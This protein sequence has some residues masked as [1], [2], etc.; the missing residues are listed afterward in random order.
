M[1]MRVASILR[2]RSP[3]WL[4]V[5]LLV[6]AIEP[7]SAARS[8]TDLF[9]E[10]G[11]PLGYALVFLFA[12]IPWFEIF[13]VIPV[14][15]GL[16]MNAVAVA[17]FAF[18]GNALSVYAVIAF[19]GRVRAWWTRRRTE[20]E[21][22]E[23]AGGRARAIWDRYGLAG[24]ALCSPMVTGVHLAALIALATGSEKRAVGAWLTASIALWTVILTAVSYYGFDFVA[25]L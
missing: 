13:L 6:I 5:G 4:V 17:V 3:P 8:A 21:P 16:G 7:V 25:G 2:R 22:R 24:L 12:A 19:H 15:I 1:T 11:G 23:R 18:L 14:G 20:G 9:V 10:S